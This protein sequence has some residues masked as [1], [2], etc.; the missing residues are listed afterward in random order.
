M[1]A[2]INNQPLW[3]RPRRSRASW[4]MGLVWFFLASVAGGQESNSTGY[5][6]SGGFGLDTLD[7]QNLGFA[8]SSGFTLDTGEVQGLATPGTG[9]SSGFVLDT[10][11]AVNPASVDLNQ[12]GFADS[13]GFTVDTSNGTASPAD[14]NQ[15]GFEDSGG[16]TV[17]TRDPNPNENT[18]HNDS[19]GFV[20][21]TGG[22]DGSGQTGHS[23]SGGFGLDTRDNLNPTTDPDATGFEDSG[24]FTLDTI[25]SGGN[26]PIANTPPTDLNSTAPLTVAENQPV[27]TIV[28]EFNAT[29]PDVN[30]TLTYYFV[31]GAADNNNSLFTLETNGTLKTAT[32]FDYENNESNYSVCLKVM[33]ESNAT[34]EGNFTILLSNTCYVSSK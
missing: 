21:N 7:V 24:G 33:D 3:G 34:I 17:D 32:I 26:P 11:G 29:D 23:D 4:V 28:G 5:T 22:N 1:L 30:S 6:D 16:F 8:E 13:G 19:G 14:S 12:T 10:Q 27:G 31:N 2:K 20:L 18:G 15:S 9:V 25:G